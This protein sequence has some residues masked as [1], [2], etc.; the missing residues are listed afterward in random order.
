MRKKI[1][2]VLFGGC[3]SEYEVSL[4]SAYSV[5]EH[6]DRQTYKVLPIGITKEGKWFIYLGDIEKIPQDIWMQEGIK[7]HLSPSMGDGIVVEQNE[8][9][10]ADYLGISDARYIM[11][12]CVFPVLHGKNGEDG[13][14]QGLLKLANIP[15]V[16][17]GMESSIVG[18]DKDL[19]HL[20]CAKNNICVPSSFSYKRIDKKS[21][22]E[23]ASKLGY[24][25]FVKPS[26]AGSSMGITKVHCE[27]ELMDAIQKALEHDDLV[28]MEE[29]IDGFEVG[30]AV[31][32]DE[33]GEVVVSKADEIELFVDWFDYDEKYSQFKSKIH[34]PA[35]VSEEKQLEIQEMAKE[36]YKVLGC[37]GFA[38]VDIFL[39]KG[40]RLVF[41]EINTIPGMTSCSRFPNMLLSIGISYSQMLK[42]FIENTLSTRV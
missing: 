6:I 8:R 38:R 37:D 19:A 15:V 32:T 22:L 36:I 21:Q 18:M 28:I 41:N 33:K 27:D 40:G 25:L 34:M 10:L 4:K 7:A 23:A 16:G 3:S 30:C 14:I 5:L 31:F 2:C 1:V 39:E 13:T 26:K 9:K 12:D 24:P 17:C 11:P 29:N 20:I 42:I 35:R